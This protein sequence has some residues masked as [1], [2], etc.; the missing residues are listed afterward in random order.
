MAKYSTTIP[1][2]QFWNSL[3]L[4]DCP[5]DEQIVGLWL[6]LVQ[7]IMEERVQKVL[8]NQFQIILSGLLKQA[9][10]T[11]ILVTSRDVESYCARALLL[12]SF[13]LPFFLH[14]RNS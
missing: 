2:I 9:T 10:Y 14:T 8:K 7:E 12:I 6:S 5:K 11:G 3:L 4:S 13:F 1:T